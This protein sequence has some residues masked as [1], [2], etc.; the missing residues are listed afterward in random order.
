M[1]DLSRSILLTFMI[2][3]IAACGQATPEPSA[4]P[5]PSATPVPTSTPA[6][7][8]ITVESLTTNEPAF[9]RFINTAPASDA[10]N[11]YLGLSTIATNLAYTQFT[12]STQVDSGQY[13]LKILPSGS[14]QG[15]P[16]LLE[17]ELSV[18]GGETLMVLIVEKDN[19]LGLTILPEKQEPLNAG[20]SIITAINATI[21][22]SQTILRNGE[23]DITVALK[24]G[25]QVT[26]PI[27]ATDDNPRI[28]FQ[29]GS[30]TVNFDEDLRE[31]Q[32]YT[33]IAAGSTAQPTII[34]FRTTAPSRVAVRALNASAEVA[35]ID[36][37]LGET[38]LNS[39]AGYGRPTERKSFASGE[40]TALVYPAGADRSRV[41]PLLNSVMRLDNGEN[42]A[43]ILLG[44]AN[45]LSL[46]AFPENL[47]AVAPDKA[48]LLLLNTLPDAE[49]VIVQ[50]TSG[51]IGGEQR[52]D[53]GQRPT[54]LSLDAGTYSFVMGA[55]QDLNPATTIEIAENVQLE[56][57]TS[58]LYLVTGRMDSQPVIL[59]E[60]VDT[61]KTLGGDDAVDPVAR[62][63]P[64][65]IRFINAVEGQIL[66][67]FSNGNALLAELGYGQGSAL[68]PVS[69]RNSILEIQAAGGDITLAQAETTFEAGS[70]YTVIAYDADDDTQRLAVIADDSLIFDGSSPHLRLINISGTEDANLGL[71]FSEP[72]PTPPAPI[73]GGEAP[74][75]E[76]SSGSLTLPFGVQKLVSDVIRASASSVILMPVGVFDLIVIHSQRNEIVITVAGQSLDAGVH[77]DVIAYQKTEGE[78]FQGFVI[79][80]PQPPA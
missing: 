48:R 71:A 62:A 33:L 54:E 43:L 13:D 12:E 1:R 51:S 45:D 75:Q 9:V 22:G 14:R 77:T 28:S 59:S 66:D 49:T 10:L 46:M 21:D 15:D 23:T 57:G 2:L 31:R 37:Y 47:T 74:T 30:G 60:K 25:E 20:E 80:Y 38:L 79:Q 32:N 42:I 11:V 44:K 63:N 40:Y 56:A 61:D 4:T 5:A 18:K 24:N 35:S 34:R 55:L 8:P 41:E 67:L 6:P 17:T 72:V 64:A 52:L 26:T 69:D 76:A 50:S 16:A 65:Q 27:L 73:N 29:I 36:V 70:R 39:N 53:Y 58:Y 19:Q 3:L 7:T 68:L 78:A